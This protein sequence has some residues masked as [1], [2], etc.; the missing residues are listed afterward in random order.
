[1][2]KFIQQVKQFFTNI[3]QIKIDKQSK[4]KFIED[5]N[6]E[7][8]DPK[9]KFN[10]FKLALSE[11]YSSV[12]GI[13]SIPENYQLAASDIMKYQKLNEIVRP[14]NV[15]LATELNWGEYLKAPDFYYI[16]TDDAENT[17][18]E[19]ESCSYIAEWKFAPILEQQPNFWW[20][21]AAFI[22]INILILGAAIALPIILI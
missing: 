20:Q 22:G 9:S 7:M 19:E 2:N 6:L 5:I 12:T 10:K 16:D 11:D 13:I 17:I 14:I 18:K 4:E 21:M 15:Y 8:A 3:K 1:M